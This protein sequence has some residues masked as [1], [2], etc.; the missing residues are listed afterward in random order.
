MLIVLG[1]MLDF[2]EKPPRF[3]LKDGDRVVLVGSALIEREQ[4][5]GDLEAMLHIIF[6]RSQFTVRNLGWSGDTVWGDAR[7]GFGTQQDGFKKLVDQIKAE[8]PTVLIFGYGTNESFAG[9]AGIDRF[10]QGFDRLVKA[11]KG[12]QCRLLFLSPPYFEKGQYPSSID[13]SVYEKNFDLYR[14]AVQRVADK[15]NGIYIHLNLN[16][17]RRSNQFPCSDDGILPDA[18]GYAIL[19][20]M[21]AKELGWLPSIEE[22]AIEKEQ[23]LGIRL[24]NALKPLFLEKNELYFH[25]YRPQNDTYLHGFRKHEQGQNAKEVPQFDRM[26][27]ELDRKIIETKLKLVSEKK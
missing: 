1:L 14:T 11:V 9:P 26:V 19:G 2:Q 27:E 6:P 22:D 16:D 7:A 13:R 12:D 24:R 8:K 17:T 21:V 23:T 18:T 5:Y 15:F 4:R 3:E 10:V 20:S 25:R